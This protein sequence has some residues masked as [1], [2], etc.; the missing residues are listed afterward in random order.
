MKYIQDEWIRSSENDYAYG[1]PTKYSGSKNFLLTHYTEASNITLPFNVEQYD[2]K[3]YDK[4]A[5][6]II[7]YHE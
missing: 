3:D 5:A 2:W 6:H 7:L 1:L 4:M